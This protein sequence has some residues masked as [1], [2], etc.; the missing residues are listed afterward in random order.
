ML[1]IYCI[2][3]ED[4]MK[5]II[6]IISVLGLLASCDLFTPKVEIKFDRETFNTQRQLWQSSNIK[7]YSYHLRA[8]GFIGYDGTIIVENGEYREN[9]PS[10]GSDEFSGYFRHYSSID[11][12]YSWIELEFTSNNNKKPE[13]GYHLEEIVVLYDEALHI[14]VEV[15]D[16]YHVSPGVSIT[17]TFDYYISDFKVVR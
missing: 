4:N 6:V 14:P 12:V 15:H 3:S 7:N 13:R 5:K 9:R 11:E 17:G 8:V 1:L 16:K 10:E 2:M